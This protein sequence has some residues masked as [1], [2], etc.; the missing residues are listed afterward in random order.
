MF[1]HQKIACIE[2]K[3]LRAFLK[4]KLYKYFEFRKLCIIRKIM[5]IFLNVKILNV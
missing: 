5:Y 3:K 1:I 4:K 2:Y